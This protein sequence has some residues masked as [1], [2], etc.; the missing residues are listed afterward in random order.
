VRF[1]GDAEMP[2]QCVPHPL[3]RSHNKNIKLT[4]NLTTAT[5]ANGC[6]EDSRV[7]LSDQ[8]IGG[9]NCIQ[10]SGSTVKDTSFNLLGDLNNQC[11]NM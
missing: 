10:V 4:F 1:D 9:G 2:M 5:K 8:S 7:C 11:L 6:R 3:M